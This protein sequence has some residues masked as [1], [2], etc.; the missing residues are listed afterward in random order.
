MKELEKP[1]HD[2]GFMLGDT[3]RK[4]PVEPLL[5]AGLGPP[6]FDV[7]LPT[8]EIRHVISDPSY[9]PGMRNGQ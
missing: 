1:D 8:G 7:E 5:L 9:V 2:W 6:P 4:L 3:F